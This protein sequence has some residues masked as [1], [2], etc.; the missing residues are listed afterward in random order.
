[1]G[2]ARRPRSE[3]A[4][5][6]VGDQLRRRRAEAD[7]VEHPRVGR[8]G[9]REAVR[10][11]ADHDQPRVDARRRAVVAKSL[12]RSR[13][14]AASVA[15]VTWSCGRDADSNRNGARTCNRPS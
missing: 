2:A 13:S 4:A 11:H 10:D 12:G 14:R 6:E 7:D 3:G 9:D 15:A 8:V 5:G 1:M